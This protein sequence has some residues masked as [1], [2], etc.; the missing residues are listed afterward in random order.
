M[1][2]FLT[3]NLVTPV[4]ENL[5]LYQLPLKDKYY[6]I[7]PWSF[8]VSPERFLFFSP[9]FPLFFFLLSFFFKCLCEREDDPNDR[10]N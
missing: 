10:N 6:Q 1:F 4:V 7:H 3:C 9:N 8:D 5:Y 2:E